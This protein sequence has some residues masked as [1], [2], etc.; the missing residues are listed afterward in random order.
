MSSIELKR[1]DR[2]VQLSKSGLYLTAG[3]QVVHLS[4]ADGQSDKLI[5]KKVM[6]PTAA[7]VCARSRLMRVLRS[8]LCDMALQGDKNSIAVPVNEGINVK[9]DIVYGE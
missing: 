4:A 3:S 6:R 1:V 5:V 9:F 2:H 7:C 8:L